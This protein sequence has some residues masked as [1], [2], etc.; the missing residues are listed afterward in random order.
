[1]ATIYKVERSRKWCFTLPNY[2][3]EELDKI[4]GIECLYLIYG[5]EIAPTTNTPHLQ[6][7]I[8]FKSQKRLTTLKKFLERAHWEVAKGSVEQNITYCSKEDPS[9]YERGDRPVTKS[10]RIKI[11]TKNMLESDL[12]NGPRKLATKRLLLG[13]ENEKQMF[14]EILNNQLE[15]PTIVYVTGASGAGKTYF[16]LKDSITKYGYKNVATLRFDKNGFAHI[17][18]PHAECIVIMEFRPSCIDATT[19]LELTDGYGMHLNVKGGGFYIRP[20]A[21]YIC[22]ILPPE[23][24]YREEINIQ[25]MRRITQIVNMDENPYHSDTE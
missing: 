24:I 25:F 12:L 5:Q 11:D 18:D 10:K 7:F 13:M 14:K 3:E 17:N 6:G 16:A 22:S 1:M 2:T 4:S 8:I 19:F 23:Q 20:K 9:P 21:I 15:K